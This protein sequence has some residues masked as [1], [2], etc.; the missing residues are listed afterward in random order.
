MLNTN[1]VLPFPPM[2]LQAIDYALTEWNA[3]VISLSLSC[4]Q[5]TSKLRQAVEKA[6]NQNVVFMAAAGNLGNRSDIPY[7]AIEERVFKIFA[8]NSHGYA[9]GFSPQ[10][11][12]PDVRYSYHIL[13]C[14]VVSAWPCK[15]QAQA[16]P[17]LC[18]IR[19]RDHNH[20]DVSGCHLGTMMSGSSFATPIAAALLGII[21][22]FYDTNKDKI[23]LD[24]GIEGLF[25]T[26]KAVS[27][28]FSKM[29][30]GG[31]QAPYNYL[32]PT[33]G[34]NN[35]FNFK[36]YKGGNRNAQGQDYIA[37]FAQK[38]AEAINQGN[39]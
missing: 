21:Y 19:R 36:T 23:R 2:H 17:K 1:H 18:L 10:A 34:S 15:L 31:K 26:P 14:D 27:A 29:S 39:I 35:F 6:V 8:T 22:Q 4:E 33:R 16:Q 32:D 38:L 24:E 13:G 9:A 5:P 12:Q 30:V 11:T 20:S 7:P 25:K 37:F 28:I 3:D